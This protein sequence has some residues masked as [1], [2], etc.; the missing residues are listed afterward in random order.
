MPTV[1]D[2]PSDLLIKR[3]CE[4]LRRMPQVAP[5]AWAYYAKTG[6][7]TERPSYDRDW[8]YTRV[9]SLLRKIYLHGPIGLSKLEA[10]YG[11]RKA[12]GFAP[13]HHRDGGGSNIRKALHQ[14]EAAGL[15]AKQTTKGRVVTTKGRSLLDRLSNEI[16]K[17]LVKT[18]PELA[19][20]G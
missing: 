7:H 19:R 4:H 9:A 18:N 11:G 20:Y 10:I 15:V 12:V 13:A 2:V 6:S 14:L 5:P 1:H 17:E 8:W 16:F 3:L